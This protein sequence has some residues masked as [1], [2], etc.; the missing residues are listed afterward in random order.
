M[1]IGRRAELALLREEL[2]SPRASLAVIYGRRRVG[3]STLIREAIRDATHVFY[4]ATRVTSSLNLEAFK[5]EIARALGNDE[6]LTGITD[7]LALLHYLARAAE[8]RPGLVIVLDEFPYLVD[9]D[10]SLPSIIQKFWDSAAARTGNLKVLLC[11]S[12]IS[13]MEE[14]LAERNPLYG[15]KTFVLDLPPL[16][17]RE[18]AQF[19]PRRTAQDKLLTCGIF[20]GIPFYL[21]LLDRGATL[22]ANIIRL[23]LTQTGS[24]IDEPVVLLQSELREVSRYASVLAAI[25]DGCTK[26]GEI[27]GR[28]REISDSRALGPYLEKLERMRLIRIVRSLDAGPKERDRRYLIADPLIAFWY[29]FVQ[30]NLSSVAQ[31]F[32]AEVW[33]HQIAPHLDEFMGGVFE[34]ICR[35]HARRFCQETFRVPAQEIGRIWQA[36]YDIDIAGRLLD[37]SMLYGECKWW[38]DL[39]GENVLDELIQRASQTDYGRNNSQRRFVLYAR[40]GFTASLHRRAASQPGIALHTPQTMLQSAATRAHAPKHRARA[41]R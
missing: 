11:G 5:L 29:R 2:V 26:H 41:H 37:G 17:F 28:V 16:S 4:Q 22:Q 14:L 12:M 24:L 3:K 35:E 10:P 8:L 19:A 38:R 15:R 1:F 33:R 20:G 39:V 30:P 18:A 32:G 21:Q 9:V 40:T 13:Q 36:D 27:I 23:L 25:A 6:L 7:W 31:G 34:E